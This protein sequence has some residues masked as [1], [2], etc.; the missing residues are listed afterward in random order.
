MCF[1]S[2]FCFLSSFFRSK[3]TKHYIIH[4]PTIENLSSKLLK[5]FLFSKT[6]FLCWGLF[7][8]FKFRKFQKSQKK[9]KYAKQTLK[10]KNLKLKNV[11][12]MEEQKQTKRKTKSIEKRKLK[13]THFLKKKKISQHDTQPPN[14]T[15]NQPHKPPNTQ[16][17]LTPETNPTPSPTNHPAF[18]FFSIFLFV[19]E[20]KLRN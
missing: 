6:N 12:Q 13:F 11:N 18:C 14:P 9:A 2:R 3:N 20:L 15:T 19:A 8:K 10:T 1:V 7:E 5:S 17:N 4:D 16:P